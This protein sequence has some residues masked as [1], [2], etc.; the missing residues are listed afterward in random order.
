[1]IIFQG[2]ILKR[3][4]ELIEVK[5]QQ[6]QLS[7]DKL[8]I[9]LEKKGYEVG[10]ALVDDFQ[11]EYLEIA[12]AIK[13]PLSVSETLLA[14]MTNLTLPVQSIGV[15]DIILQQNKKSFPRLVLFEAFVELLIQKKSYL[16]LRKP[17]YI[18]G[19]QALAKVALGILTQLGFSKIF[20][21]GNQIQSLELMVKNFSKQ[22][23]SLEI[24]VFEISEITQNTEVGGILINTKS[25]K[26]GSEELEL[27][28]YFNFLSASALVLDFCNVKELFEESQRAELNYLSCH[29]VEDVWTRQVSEWL[30]GGDADGY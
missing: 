20:V 4:I 19:D 9:E 10:L 11:F 7:F 26:A 15:F 13:I 18:V 6:P 16:D 27:T 1:M 17:A 3:K 30:I 12:D 5:S 23:F 25:L 14:S 22:N 24:Q 2:V 21:Y 29:D 28:S 8:K